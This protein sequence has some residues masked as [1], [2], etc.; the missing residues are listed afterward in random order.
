MGRVISA[1]IRRFNGFA[2]IESPDSCLY[3]ML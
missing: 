1:F 3:L 2:S